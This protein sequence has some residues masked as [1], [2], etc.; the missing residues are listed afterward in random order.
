MDKNETINNLKEDIQDI[1]SIVNR[2]ENTN[3][4][5]Q[6]DIDLALSKVRNLYELFLKFNSKET[7]MSDNQEKEISTITKQTIQQ[8]KKVLKEDIQIKE[9]E[10]SEQDPSQKNQVKK[11]ENKSE[12]E[13]TEAAAEPEFIIET[14]SKKEIITE[15]K[16]T[17]GS[18][19]IVADKFQTKK[20]VHDNIAKNGSKNDMSTKMNSKPIKDINAAIGLND[21]FIFIRELF[22]NNKDHYN[23]TIQVLN[24]F[25]TF[26][27]AIVFLNE[28]FDWDAEDA[29]FIRLTE[30]V[31]RK[32]L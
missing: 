31:R 20:F 4:F 29:N 6:L 16:S 10:I 9:K 23:E 12:Q 30:L 7:Y 21:K 5:H 28:N 26:E 8:Q 3:K 32:Y 24:N 2:F 22:D 18:S 19:E 17:N 27:N 15:S 11:I 14:P 13:T 1:Y 25:D